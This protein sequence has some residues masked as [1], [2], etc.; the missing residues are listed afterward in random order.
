MSKKFVLSLML[1]A[2]FSAPAFAHGASS[3]PLLGALV[4]AG[5]HG[6]IATVG[7]AVGQQNRGA[8]SL[9]D[10]NLNLLNG[11]VKANIGVDQSSRQS[12]SLLNIGATVLGGGVGNRGGW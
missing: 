2:S 10:V 5:N 7:A 11:A 8:S 6:G 1:A 4:T 9:A 3:V 12:T